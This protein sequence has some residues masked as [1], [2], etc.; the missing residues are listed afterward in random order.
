MDESR[1]T[2]SLM[3]LNTVA[4]A[5]LTPWFLSHVRQADAQEAPVDVLTSRKNEIARHLPNIEL[6][7]QENRPVRFYDDLVK[8]KK[9]LINFMYTD[10]TKTCP[11]TTANLVKVQNAFGDRMGRDVFF[12]SVTLTPDHDTPERLREYAAQHGCGRGWSYLTG[13]VEDITRLRRHLGV[14]ND[15]PDVSQ[16]VGILTYGNEPEGK[17]GATAALAPSGQIVRTVTAKFDGWV[18]RPWPERA[19]NGG[20]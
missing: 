6:R 9:V 11:T 19:S 2:M 4:L 1:R 18:A 17:W 10:C 7:T 13:S 8:G 15:N 3:A 12:L 16:H 14:Y 20:K 5:G